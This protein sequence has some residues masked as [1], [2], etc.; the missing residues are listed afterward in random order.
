MTMDSNI[1]SHTQFNI[2]RQK[3]L[4]GI[5]LILKA[6]VS[7]QAKI[8]ALKTS[9]LPQLI[10][11]ARYASWSL[12]QYQDI[13]RIIEHAYK[14]IA[15]CMHSHPNALLYMNL[16]DGGL[17][18]PKFSLECN[19]GK[20]RL[21]TRMD[22][23]SGYRRAIAQS[24][25]GRGARSQGITIPIGHG[26]LINKPLQLYW[27]TSLLQELQERKLFMH[28]HG[29]LA[30]DDIYHWN[31]IPPKA[32]RLATQ[33]EAADI[34]ISTTAE[35]NDNIVQ[36]PLRTAQ[37]WEIKTPNNFRIKEI[38]SYSGD[39]IDFMEWIAPMPVT[40]GQKLSLAMTG[41]PI[42][43][44]P[45]GAHGTHRETYDNFFPP[46]CQTRL[47]ILSPEK[48]DETFLQITSKVT[49]IKVKSPL[50][51]QPFT[52]PTHILE[53]LHNAGHRA[54]EIFT[55]GSYDR[56]STPPRGGGAVVFKI[57]NSMYTCIKILKDI[58]VASVYDIELAAL[59][60][61]RIAS[62][63]SSKLCCIYS[64]S[65]ASLNT[66]ASIDKGEFQKKP[67]QHMVNQSQLYSNREYKWIQSHVEKRKKD[68][69]TWTEAEVGNYIADKMAEHEQNNPIAGPPIVL[70]T[71]PHLV[72][73]NTIMVLKL[74]TIIDFLK[75]HNSF[76]IQT[77]T[78]SFLGSLK[79]LHLE[80]M[81][82]CYLAT[83]DQY[84]AKR[85]PGS[86]PMPFWTM[87]CTQVLTH[88]NRISKL[89]RENSL[90]SRIIY[91]KS[92]TTG[93]QYKYGVTDT[94]VP[95][96]CCGH[97]LET[98]HHILF[99]CHNSVMEDARHKA[100]ITIN[101]IIKKQIKK[102]PR[103]R[104]LIDFLR[105]HAFSGT[106]TEL[107]TGLWSRKLLTL[108][109]NKLLQK[110]YQG[111]YKISTIL[112][113]T[114]IYTDAAKQIY[115]IRNTVLRNPAVTVSAVYTE[116]VTH[117]ITEYF[118]ADETKTNKQKKDKDTDKDKV[119]SRA[120]KQ[121]VSK[122]DIV[123]PTKMHNDNDIPQ[124]RNAT[125][126]TEMTEYPVSSILE[127]YSI[128]P[129]FQKRTDFP[130][131]LSTPHAHKKKK[132]VK[133]RVDKRLLPHPDHRTTD[134][135]I[136]ADLFTSNTHAQDP[137]ATPVRGKCSRY[138]R[139]D[140][141]DDDNQTSPTVDIHY[142]HNNTNNNT[143]NNTITDSKPL[144]GYT[145]HVNHIHTPIHTPES[146][147]CPCSP[148]REG[149]G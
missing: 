65:E 30:M 149:V 61:A 104:I 45:V 142:Y 81:C 112:R 75:Q 99:N 77:P 19:L 47:L 55:D 60:V 96:P 9:L 87:K 17:E 118:T 39:N 52:P 129:H 53:L 63:T 31:I 27:V 72:T 37:V 12:Q 10:F 2:T 42:S 115:I 36:I 83:R 8:V 41:N 148:P 38:I 107:W 130:A 48:H 59:A 121:A 6:P 122:T 120:D 25:L 128:K 145:T 89:L 15:H 24:L 68:Y 7:A 138:I 140:T 131:T 29:R 141:N 86:P 132:L 113:L 103:L 64:D 67:L 139:S 46:H 133:I 90:R 20:L 114:R 117:K 23:S 126:N 135:S 4:T 123:H 137:H 144:A 35:A 1:T 43:P 143:N 146:A 62:T 127:N 82:R 71:L 136:N 32:G 70:H 11:A 58:N 95:C 93:N 101:T 78:Q 56:T 147:N 66:M 97:G 74:S 3:A 40:I 26:A 69:N 54:H 13:D 84:R 51:I 111:K 109:E 80:D 57:T 106:S 108:V 100:I 125:I 18:L 119:E 21:L 34:G 94:Q 79:Q 102:H 124:L 105:D 14:E 110:P 116:R 22:Q 16:A 134:W 85:K 49:H 73:I 91:N 98:Q 76:S 92:W 33:C 5:A 28:I 88:T 44:Y 50:P